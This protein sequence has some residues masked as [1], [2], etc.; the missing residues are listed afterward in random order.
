MVVVT[1]A[2]VAM[3]V[4]AMVAMVVVAMVAIVVAA[5]AAELLDHYPEGPDGVICMQG[6]A[7]G[8]R[9]GSIGGVR[10]RRCDEHHDAPHHR[11]R[12]LPLLLPP[13]PLWRDTVVNPHFH[14]DRRHR[15]SLATAVFK[16]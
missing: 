5:A 4:V 13:A 12:L 7:S 9:L 1:M 3:V 2:V 6:Q 14:F 11:C 15:R 10:N 16:P 8:G